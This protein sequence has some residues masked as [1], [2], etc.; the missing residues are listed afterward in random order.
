M[1]W[2]GPGVGWAGGW[3]PESGWVRRAK[4]VAIQ[5][6]TGAWARYTGGQGGAAL[7]RA[8]T[9][10]V[11][12]SCSQRRS[13]RG[14]MVD[15]RLD[16]Y[17]WKVGSPMK[18]IKGQGMGPDREGGGGGGGGEGGRIWR[19]ARDPALYGGVR[20]YGPRGG[21][22]SYVLCIRVHGVF[23]LVYCRRL[24]GNRAACGAN[25]RTGSRAAPGAAAVACAA[26]TAGAD[27]QDGPTG[28]PPVGRLGRP[29]T[30]PSQPRDGGGWHVIDHGTSAANKRPETRQRARAG[31][32]RG[33][34]GAS[35]VEAKLP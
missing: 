24:G 29:P 12:G 19:K 35:P 10:T 31:C 5:P 25:E 20:H 28:S 18:A 9:Y 23:V 15:N 32:K 6:K 11:Q 21:L 4:A 16:L 27:L 14:V 2:G 7:G 3:G 1:V 17:L 22:A 26:S 8:H 34:A 13:R 33:A 30:E